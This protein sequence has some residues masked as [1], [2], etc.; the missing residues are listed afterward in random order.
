MILIVPQ[1]KRRDALVS[2]LNVVLYRADVEGS[3]TDAT[4]AQK[5]HDR[6]RRKERAQAKVAFEQHKGKPA[7]TYDEL[8]RR[9]LGE[10][11]KQLAQLEPGAFYSMPMAP[12]MSPL[13]TSLAATPWTDVTKPAGADQ[14]LQFDD[15]TMSLSTR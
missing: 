3:L 14:S 4:C 8:L 10:H 2:A 12:A 6:L 7:L 11:L 5:H 9:H 15:D 1:S 13:Q